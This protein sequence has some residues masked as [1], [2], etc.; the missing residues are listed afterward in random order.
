LTI[1][2][3]QA[4]AARLLLGWTKDRLAGEAGVSA[5]T[6]GKFESGKLRLSV[7]SVSTIQRA[8]ESADV[9]F[10]DGDPGVK[11]TRRP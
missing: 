11:L 6:V 3:Q 2:G 7:L 5:T 9:E 1:T 8:L 10:V 4:K